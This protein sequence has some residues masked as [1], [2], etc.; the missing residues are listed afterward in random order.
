MQEQ[1]TVDCSKCKPNLMQAIH[2]AVENSDA[3]CSHPNPTTAFASPSLTLENVASMACQAHATS[4]GLLATLPSQGQS[5][6]GKTEAVTITTFTRTTAFSNNSQQTQPTRECNTP[7]DY[8]NAKTLRLNHCC[9]EQT[10]PNIICIG[11][12][13]MDTP[14]ALAWLYVGAST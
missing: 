5:Q 10:C 12:D 9:Q 4:A 6:K 11:G 13:P 14:H 8:T 2:E 7:A 1:H 3:I